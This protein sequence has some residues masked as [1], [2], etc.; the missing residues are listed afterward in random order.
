MS[1]AQEQLEFRNFGLW[2][3]VLSGC[4]AQVRHNYIES[5]E[6]EVLA[7]QTEVE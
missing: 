7:K 3:S 5:V 4:L 1:N 6:T 2:F